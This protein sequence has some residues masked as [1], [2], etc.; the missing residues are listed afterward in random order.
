MNSKL[1]KTPKIMECSV[2]NFEKYGLYHK[3]ISVDYMLPQYGVSVLAHNGV[4]LGITNRT[5]YDFSKDKNDFINL[6]TT[7]DI[8]YWMPIP[9]PLIGKTK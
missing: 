2:E 9:K 3:W 5:H 7:Y 8:K 6:I 1:K 4:S